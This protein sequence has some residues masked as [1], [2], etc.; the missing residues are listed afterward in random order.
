MY[1]I[2]ITITCNNKN[3]RLQITF[4]LPKTCNRLHVI[5]ITDYNYNRSDLHKSYVAELGF[6]FVNP[7]SAVRCSTNCTLGIER[8][9][10][11]HHLLD[12]Y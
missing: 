3:Q 8:M 10:L 11:R 12:M 5:M 4:Q 6:Q 7:G 9:P 2:T 1:S